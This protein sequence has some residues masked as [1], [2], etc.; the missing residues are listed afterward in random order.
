MQIYVVSTT[1]ISVLDTDL[2][3]YERFPSH[4][5]RVARTGG[6]VRVQSIAGKRYRPYQSASASISSGVRFLATSAMMGA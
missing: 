2:F 3:E 4:A 1:D 6:A 5:K